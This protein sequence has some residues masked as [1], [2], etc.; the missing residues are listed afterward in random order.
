MACKAWKGVNDKTLLFGGEAAR[1]ILPEVY[2]AFFFDP[3][4]PIL[5]SFNG[6]E[7]WKNLIAVLKK[8]AVPVPWELLPTAIS[9]YIRT[10]EGEDRLC[11]KNGS[12]CWTENGGVEERP[13]I[14]PSTLEE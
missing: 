13:F 10:P 9:I 8:A 2:N 5:D 4:E 11:Q 3:R 1:T 12:L 7:Y 14:C 6:E